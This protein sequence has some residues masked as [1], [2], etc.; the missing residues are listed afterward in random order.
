M[1]MSLVALWHLG[2]TNFKLFMI[3]KDYLK[4]H[5]EP[6][7][8]SDKKPILWHCSKVSQLSHVNSVYALS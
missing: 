8:H 5:C 6:V 3:I 7:L 1:E 2:W 4:P